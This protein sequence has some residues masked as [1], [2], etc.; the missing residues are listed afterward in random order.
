[1][2][3]IKIIVRKMMNNRWL[4]SSLFLGLLI[5]VALVASIPIF[6]SGVLQK[7]LIS[8]LDNHYIENQEYPGEFS[9]SVN[10]SQDDDIDRINTLENVEIIN[11]ELINEVVIPL[12]TKTTIL[13][14]VPLKINNESGPQ[15]LSTRIMSIS[16]IEDHIR[17][18]DGSLPSEEIADNTYEALVPEKALLTRDM[19][20]GNTFTITAGDQEIQIKPVGTFVAKDINDPFWTMSPDSYSQDFIIPESLYRNEMLK[21]N[22]ELLNTAKFTAVFDY[23]LT[24]KENI[25]HLL[26]LERNVQTEVNIL[27]ET[28]V[29]VTFPMKEILLEY[30]DNAKQLKTML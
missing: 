25:N 16:N 14:T 5:T 7:L 4:T 20:L 27:M 9:Y 22:E 26:T 11:E 3:I 23:R 17:I 30:L 10:F 8:D 15:T 2:A 18:T 29:L 12:M 21:I 24:K 28:I 6:T 19:V 13:S 1:M